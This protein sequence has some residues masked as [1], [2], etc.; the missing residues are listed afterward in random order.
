MR[1]GYERVIAHRCGKLFAGVAAQEGTV[2]NVDEATKLITVTYKDKST[3]VF[4]YGERYV[5]FQ[6][7]YATHHI[8]S[9]VKV[10]QKLKKGDIITYNR[11]FFNLD[12][13]SKQLDMT[14]GTMAMVALIEMDVNLEDASLISPR[15]AQKLSIEPTNT[16]VVTLPK[17]SLIHSYV[18]VGQ[19]VKNTDPLMIFEEDPGLGDT[20]FQTASEET[21]R[22]LG[23]INRSIPEA[24]F[25][26]TVVKIEA[27]YG[28]PI[29]EMNPS[30]ATIVRAAVAEQNRAA[31]LAANTDDAE[32][33]PP[34]EV[35]PDGLKYNGVQ[36]DNDTVTLTFYIKEL[37]S[38]TVGDKICLG[39]CLKNTI[40]SIS[41]RPQYT[42][43]GEEIDVLFSNDSVSRRITLSQN[44]MGVINR[45]IEGLEKN[46]VD[47]YF[48]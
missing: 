17:R 48:E 42:E 43:D 20:L 7:F 24:K 44:Y 13:R 28:C 26:G 47:M 14:V 33:Y 37:E 31:K 46:I 22:L 41:S 9:I 39:T 27:H 1:T 23:D 29:S 15:L 10:G 5:P 30:L 3:A 34:N 38:T 45:V 25:S 19:T 8:E 21:Q 2:T 35:L 4:P 11:G 12:K 36:Y 18:K 40:S 32:E 16:R 6:G